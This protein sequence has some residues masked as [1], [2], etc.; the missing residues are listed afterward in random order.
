MNDKIRNYFPILFVILISLGAIFPLFHSG[1][2]PMHDDTQVARVYEMAKSLRDGMFPVRWVQDLGYGYGYPIFNFYAPLAYYVGG[3][4][5][6][7]ADA[8]F[9]AKVMIFFGVVLSGITMYLLGKA[10]WGQWG[11]IFSAI[12]YVYAPYHAVDLYVRGDIA[13]LWAYVFFPLALLGIWFL[14][15]NILVKGI[16]VGSLGFAGVILS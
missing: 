14:Y 1:F 8:L 6:L 11:G 10:L 5:A 3:M 7:F 9:A 15:K 16:I 4:I 13:E 2:F 12:L